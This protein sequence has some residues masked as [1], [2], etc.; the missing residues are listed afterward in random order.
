MKFNLINMEKYE[1]KEHFNHYANE[2][3]CSYSLTSNINVTKF[4]NEIKK[5]N[6]KFY[7]AFIYVVTQ[8][9]NSMKEFKMAV[10]E[11]GKLGF[12]D[13]VSASYVIFHEDDKTFSCAFTKYN[14]EFNIFYKNITDD[15]ERYKD[16]KGFETIKSDLNSFPI[17]C[18]PW[19]N[20]TGFNLNLPVNGNFYAPIITWGKYKN[21]NGIIEMPVT[22]QINHA[23]A[24][25]Y[26]TSMLFEKIQEGCLS[27]IKS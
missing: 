18:L 12:Y 8:A 20:Y 16:V 27:F 23:V 22:I 6:Y 25:G 5:N 3:I 9:V 24:D 11:N 4:I 14:S 26:H 21:N 2:D 13:E 1:R 15:M 17:S 19:L 10:D 7:P